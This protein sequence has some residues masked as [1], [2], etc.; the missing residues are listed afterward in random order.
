MRINEIIVESCCEDCRA[1]PLDEA[2][3]EL[4]IEEGQTWARVGNKV[5]RKFRCS[6]GPRH[7]RVVSKPGQCF[8][9]PDVKKRMT[10]KRTKAKQGN[11]M[12]KKAKRTKR[13]NAASRRVQQLNK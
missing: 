11:R 9:P 13:A 12:A 10:L 4:P 5:V 2:G 7:G 6:G 8:A 1:I 3:N